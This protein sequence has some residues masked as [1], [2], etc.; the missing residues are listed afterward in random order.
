MFAIHYFNSNTYMNL[1]RCEIYGPYENMDAA[2][3]GLMKLCESIDD[4]LFK[5][6]GTGTHARY[7]YDDLLERER[8][9]ELRYQVWAE[10]IR[11]TSP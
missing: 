10:I 11:L 7:D 9:L 6:D 2:K 5:I 3:K 1:S 4:D 8:D